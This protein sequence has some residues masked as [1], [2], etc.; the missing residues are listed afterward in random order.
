MSYDFLG[1]PVS[2]KREDLFPDPN[3]PRLGLEERPGYA[4]LDALFDPS[5]RMEALEALEA[6]GT[7]DLADTMIRQGWLP[8]DNIIGFQPAGE[9]DRWVAVEGNRRTKALS[10]LPGKLEKELKKLE[11]M[12]KPNA[13]YSK[14]DVA[15]QETW[16]GRIEALLASTE[17]LTIVP[18]IA[19]DEDELIDRLQRVLAVRHI[20]GARTWGNYAEDIWLLNRFRHLF[21]DAY[22]DEP[23]SWKQSIIEQVADEASLSSV[24]TKRS[25]KAASWFSHFRAEWE[26]ELPDGE[27]FSSSDYYLFENIAKKPWVRDQFGI[28]EDDLHINH[29]SEQVIFDWV[30]KH[31]RPGNADDNT[32]KWFR[33]ENVLLWDQIHRYDQK[34]G[35]GFAGLFDVENHE[36]VPTMFEVEAMYLSHRAQR[37]PTSVLQQLL[38][39]LNKLKADTLRLEREMMRPLLE[40]INERTETFLKMIDAA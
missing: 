22:P 19:S 18:I 40:E 33:H 26:D 7:D 21:D 29:D 11:R 15:E 16:V 13:A 27:E 34:A 38:V 4:N 30:F 12:K 37:A 8:V 36:D 14:G 1:D 5:V 23:L 10:L 31:P 20:N 3:N 39:E 25:V 24:A 28:G 2:V 35:T 6:H 32:N 9:S 17:E